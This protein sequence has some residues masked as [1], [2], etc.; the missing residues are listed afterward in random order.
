MGVLRHTDVTRLRRRAWIR[1]PLLR[2]WASLAVS[3][4]ERIA[5][6]SPNVYRRGQLAAQNALILIA[7]DSPTAPRALRALERHEEAAPLLV[8]S[9]GKLGDPWFAHC[10]QNVLLALGPD[11]VEGIRTH[12]LGKAPVSDAAL[13]AV[14]AHD[15]WLPQDHDDRARFFLLNGWWQ[16]YADLDPEGQSMHR[17]YLSASS[18]EQTQMRQKYLR[19][20]RNRD[21][22]EP[23]ILALVRQFSLM[24]EDNEVRDATG[25][26]PLQGRR[27]RLSSEGG[28]GGRSGRQG[29]GTRQERTE[30]SDGFGEAV[31][32]II[33]EALE[34][35]IDQ[36]SGSGGGSGGGTTSHGHSDSH[37]HDSGHDDRGGG[38]DW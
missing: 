28:E 3:R 27:G 9:S 22:R 31:E 30:E 23:Y 16:G 14:V 13:H 24:L 36:I 4:L 32:E 25:L 10:A 35:G 2:W 38:S 29:E 33:E 1:T 12:L 6:P 18:V 19:F 20:Y 8:Y 15:D 26:P 7:A 37:G 5:F 21:P 34:Q 11:T 17:L